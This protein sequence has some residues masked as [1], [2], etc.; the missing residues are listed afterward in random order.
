MRLKVS[1]RKGDKI[2]LPVVIDRGDKWLVARVPILGLATQ[3][4]TLKEVKENVVDLLKLYFENPH[5]PKPDLQDLNSIDI[6]L[7]TITVTVPKG[8][9]SNAKTRTAITA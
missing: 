7:T 8:A 4:R 2:Q 3:G 1:H 9:I 5:T 6:M